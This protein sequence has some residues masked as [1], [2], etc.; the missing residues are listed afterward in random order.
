MGAT[1]PL[2]SDSCSTSPCLIPAPLLDG[3]FLSFFSFTGFGVPPSSFSFAPPRFFL[4]FGGSAVAL[5]EPVPAGGGVSLPPP[6]LQFPVALSNG[7]GLLI[8]DGGATPLLLLPSSGV[9]L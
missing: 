9:P 3:C 5:V 8:D 1:E 4:S 2:L 7:G 6:L